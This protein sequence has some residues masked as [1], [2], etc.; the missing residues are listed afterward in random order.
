V[1]DNSWKN[2]QSGIILAVLFTGAVITG[3]SSSAP[4]CSDTETTDL[5]KQIAKE[6]LA[7]LQG[8]EIADQIEMSV[9][10]IRTTDSNDKTGAQQCAAQLTLKGPNGENSLDITYTSEKTDKGDEFFVNVYGL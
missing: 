2:K 6:Q 10:A 1:T 8:Q 3:C 5:V 4:K 7:K 9:D